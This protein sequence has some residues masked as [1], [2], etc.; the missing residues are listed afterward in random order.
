LK[1]LLIIVDLEGVFDARP[2]QRLGQ[3]ANEADDFFERAAHAAA[4]Q[5][6]DAVIEIIGLEIR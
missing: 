4:E 2:G 5:V 3:Q 6:L 1:E